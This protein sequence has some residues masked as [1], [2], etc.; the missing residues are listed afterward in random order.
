[1]QKF[2][3]VRNIPWRKILEFGRDVFNDER[4]PSDLKDKWKNMNKVS[5]D[6]GKWLSLSTERQ[7][8]H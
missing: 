5:F 2:P 1:M 3:G 6:N 7:P 4:V 8:N